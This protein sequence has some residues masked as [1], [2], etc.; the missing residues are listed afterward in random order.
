MQDDVKQKVKEEHDRATADNLVEKLVVWSGSSV[1][2]INSMKHAEDVV[3]HLIRDVKV[4]LLKNAQ[5]AKPR[6]LGQGS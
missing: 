4:I 2:L 6:V 3:N 5:L 1:G